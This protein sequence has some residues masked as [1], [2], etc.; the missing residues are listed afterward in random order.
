MDL[1]SVL[2]CLL[3]GVYFMWFDPC[4]L[5][6]SLWQFLSKWTGPALGFGTM[7]YVSRCVRVCV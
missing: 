6:L 3:C 7:L 1:A 5:L 2:M 4:L